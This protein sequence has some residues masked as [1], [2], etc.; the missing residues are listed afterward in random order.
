MEKKFSIQAAL[1]IT[2]D[3]LF[4]RNIGDVYEILN[5]ITGD[6]L[7]THQLPR[8]AEFAKP[9]IL[10]AYPILEDFTP[11]SLTASIEAKGWDNTYNGVIA[12]LSKEIGF[13]ITLEPAPEGVWNQKNP[14]EEL[15]EMRGGTDGIIIIKE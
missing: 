14:I 10:A 3:R 6:N 8:A 15:I 12:S 11:E 9:F 13:E 5:F 1:S 2:T 7:M 4:T